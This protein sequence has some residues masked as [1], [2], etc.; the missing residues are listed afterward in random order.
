VWTQ[1][2]EGTFKFQDDGGTNYFGFAKTDSY[3]IGANT[4]NITVSG[5]MVTLLYNITMSGRPCIWYKASLSDNSEWEQLNLPDGSAVSG[6]SHVV[7]WEQNPDPDTQVCYI[8]VGNAPSGFFKATVEVAGSAK[9][10]TNMPADLSGGIL[11]TDG[12]HKVRFVYNNGNVSMEVF[13]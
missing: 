10:M 9:F 13:Q 4:D 8:N 7:S 2:D 11:C 12:I 5:G 3:T 6:A 1:G